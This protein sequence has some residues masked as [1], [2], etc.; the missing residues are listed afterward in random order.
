MIPD[1]RFEYKMPLSVSGGVAVRLGKVRLEADVRW[2]NS[3]GDWTLYDSDSPGAAIG[4]QGSA[5]AVAQTVAFAPVTLT[6]R[7]VVNFA[8]GGRIPL[9]KR[10]ELHAGFN[11]DESPLPGTDESFRKV[12]MIGGTVGL[13]L[14]GEKLSGSLGVGF[15]SGTSPETQ[16]GIPPFIRETKVSVNTFQL[17]YSI[18]YAF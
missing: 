18:S 17:L 14:T 2:Y 1:A 7:S 4:Q 3:I 15:Q 5:P 16:I 6:Y 8:I 13:S 9:S 12:N 11:S 10:L